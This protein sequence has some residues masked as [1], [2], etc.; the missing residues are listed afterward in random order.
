MRSSN[1]PSVYAQYKLLAPTLNRESMTDPI[2]WSLYGNTL[3]G[4]FS[5]GA[6]GQHK[7]GPIGPTPQLF[8]AELASKNYNSACELMSRDRTPLVSN[9]ASI[10]SPSFPPSNQIQT[11]GQAML[12]NA[13][14]RRFGDLSGC[15]VSKQL[16]NDMDPNSPY[17]SSY[18]S[19]EPIICKPPSNPDQDVLLNRILDEPEAHMVLLTNMYMNTRRESNKYNGTR[20][21]QLFNVIEAYLK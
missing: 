8:M 6:S 2:A 10:K 3:D 5:I 15:N 7:Y 9:V 17:V 20:I 13:G 19:T 21:G 16:F 1:K 11:I 12:D 18:S 14:Q 4:Q